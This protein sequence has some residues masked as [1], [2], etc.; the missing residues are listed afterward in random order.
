[1]SLKDRT[2]KESSGTPE[3]PK[4][5]PETAAR[6]PEQPESPPGPAQAPAATTASAG[7]REGRSPHEAEQACANALR[8][9][10]D[11]ARRAAVHAYGEYLHRLQDAQIEAQK[12][13]LQAYRSFLK[14]AD[15][16]SA[17]EDGAEALLEEQVRYAREL[18]AA[19]G[20]EGLAQGYENAHRD[21]C[22]ALQQIDDRTR[23]ESERAYRKYLRALRDAITELDV[24]SA[25][26]ELTTALGYRLVAAAQMGRSVSAP[27]AESR[28]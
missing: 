28:G 17:K 13:S 14:A 23:Q 26:P 3:E 5:N 9:V 22:G 11:E 1:M 15:E 10:F 21:Y 12:R 25:D 4:A 16:A 24:E 20:P 18:E 2:L 8:S 7:G 6:T 27:A 19:W